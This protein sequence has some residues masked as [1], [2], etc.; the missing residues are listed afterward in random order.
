MAMSRALGAA[1]LNHQV[2]QLEKSV[3]ANSP[4]SG[5]WRDRKNTTPNQFNA[6]PQYSG[7]RTPMAPGIKIVHR[8]KGGDAPSPLAKE[9][10]VVKEIHTRR[11]A[12][13]EAILSQ[14]S[15]DK[16]EQG[17]K[18]ADIIVVDASVLVHALYQIKKWSKD[19]RKEVIIVPLEALNTLDLLKKGTSPLAQ[20]ARAASRILE[21]Q[22]GTNPRI[23][24]QRD[25]AFVLWDQITMKDASSADEADFKAAPSPE[26]VRRTICCTRWEIQNAN[27]TINPAGTLKLADSNDTSMAPVPLP[28]PSVPHANKFEARS[29][30]VLVAKWAEKAGIETLPVEPTLPGRG[31]GAGGDEDERPKRNHHSHH[32]PKGRRSSNTDHPHAPKACLVERPPAVMAMMEMVSQPSRVV[33]VLA[34]GEKLEPGP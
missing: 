26:W 5:N 25:D 11:P 29:S 6:P 21:A 16:G 2:E 24:V 18:D 23:R 27:T 28:A 7:K 10:P 4:S 30:G 8:K 33:R 31:A 13:N 19:G 15:G 9:K 32:G 14:P 12:V 3:S 20:R 1:F 34:R 17:D 22:V